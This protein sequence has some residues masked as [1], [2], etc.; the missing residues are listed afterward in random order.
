MPVYPTR[1]SAFLPDSEYALIKEWATK[2]DLVPGGNGIVDFRAAVPFPIP[3][4]GVEV[5]WN[6]I[7]RYRTA[8]GVERRYIQAPVQANGNFS[9]VLFEEQAM[10]ANRVEGNPNPNRLMVFLQRILAPARLE[11]DVLLVHAR[12]AEQ[13]MRFRSPSRLRQGFDGST[14]TAP[15]S[16]SV[17]TTLFSA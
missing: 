15:E 6:H 3:N 5:I 9:P 13:P 14:D 7:T 4:E 12:A 1:R 16:E 10:F 8:Q 11:G 17:I 2:T